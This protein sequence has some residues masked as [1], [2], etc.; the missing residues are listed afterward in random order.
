MPDAD[1]ACPDDKPPAGYLYLREEMR[2]EHTLLGGRMT[3]YMTGQ[4]FLFTAAAVARGTNW[5]GFYWLSGG[6]LPLVGVSGSVVMLLAIRAAY[7][8]MAV[9]REKEKR[10]DGRHP[11]VY[12]NPDGKHRHTLLFSTLMPWVFLAVWAAMPVLF[13]LF[14][15]QS[16]GGM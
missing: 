4:S 1:A 12:V 15:P 16:G 6:V 5:E 3:Y 9:W 14:R 10:Y 13:H 8:R 7:A 11:L 2:F